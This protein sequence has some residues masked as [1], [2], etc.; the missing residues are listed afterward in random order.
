MDKT[1]ERDTKE[2]K[3][4]LRSIIAWL[5]PGSGHFFLGRPWHGLLLGGTVFLMCGLG[6]YWGGHWYGVHN[7]DEVGMLA[8]VFG[9]C[10]VGTGLI[11]VMS[12]AADFAT[13]NQ[14]SLPTSEYGDRFLMVAGLLN[15]LSML[16]AYDLSVRR[17]M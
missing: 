4:V 5:V 15:Y 13:L 3:A 6:F 16:D 11:Y 12:V 7:Q 2:V 14:A 8:Y 1:N 10:N 17:K 9:L